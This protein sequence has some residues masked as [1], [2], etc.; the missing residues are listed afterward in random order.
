MFL[1]NR[2]FRV[3][4]LAVAL[5]AGALDLHVPGEARHHGLTGC[6][7]STHSRTSLHPT[8]PTHFEAA[9]E[10]VCP[11]CPG[12][13]HQLRI[14]AARLPLAILLAAPALKD[15]GETSPIPLAGKRFIT[16][17]GARGPPFV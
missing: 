2:T 5:V 8:A 6:R 17:R 3:G 16:P 13:L 15:L 12:C 11:I 14:G 4:L 1:M 10:E 7:S 9:E